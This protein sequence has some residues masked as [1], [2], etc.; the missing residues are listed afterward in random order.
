[1]EEAADLGLIVRACPSKEM[2]YQFIK[3]G[4]NFKDFVFSKFQ[5]RIQSK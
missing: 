3:G 4:I 2:E 5:Y 1:M